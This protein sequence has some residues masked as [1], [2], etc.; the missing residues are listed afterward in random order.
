MNKPARQKLFDLCKKEI[1]RYEIIGDPE[2][3]IL[4]EFRLTYK[5]QTKIGILN[6]ALDLEK[7][8]GVFGLFCRFEDATEAKKNFRHWKVNLH[9]YEDETFWQ[10]VAEH[11][12]M[13]FD[14]FKS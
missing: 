2:Y 11:L 3:S 12:T 4:G 9:E 10:D 5:L 8:S 7:G 1:E 6:V 14:K 13:I